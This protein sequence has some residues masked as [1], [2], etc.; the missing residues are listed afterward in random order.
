[1]SNVQ[2]RKC[3]FKKVVIFK[4]KRKKREVLNIQKPHSPQHLQFYTVLPP[5][6]K[7]NKLALP[8]KTYLSTNYF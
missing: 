2:Y 1:M 8:E 4:F 7:K 3:S 5:T 6:N